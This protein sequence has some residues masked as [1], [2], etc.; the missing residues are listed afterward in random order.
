MVSLKK[1]VWLI[2]TV[3]NAD[4]SLKK[5]L[6]RGYRQ[7]K[8][9]YHPPSP[10]NADIKNIINCMLCP[11]MC[12]FECPAVQASKRE[13][14]APATKSRI[15]YYL[16]M[17][18]LEKTPENIIP[19]FEGCAHCDACKEW[20]PFDFSVGDLLEGVAVD[21]FSADVLPEPLEE[22]TQRLRQNNGLYPVEK[23]KTA[24]KSLQSLDNG[25]IYYF[26]GCTTMAHMADP[27]GL[28]SGIVKISTKANVPLIARPEDRWCCGA[29]SFYAGDIEKVKELALHNQK[30]FDSLKVKSII[31]ECPECT[32]MLRE[33]YPKL[34]IELKIP[35]LHVSEWILSLINEDKISFTK[36]KTETSSINPLSFHDPCVLA[37]KLG[38]IDPPRQI[39][40]KLAP[41][42]LKES[43]Y[44]TNT[45]HC[46]GFGGLVNIA[47]PEIAA[48]MSKQRLNE[49]AQLGVTTIITSCP[50][51]E[52][53]FLKNDSEM[54]FEIKDL[55]EF[56]ASLLE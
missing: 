44:S 39:I 28:I 43:A 47:N 4:W 36:Q 16:E 10:V 55:V 53:S 51:C 37:R 17:E 2:K 38:I 23:Y 5:R 3:L 9:K 33:H 41:A 6:L 34:G 32:Y 11:N 49:F 15:A 45:T 12:R 52:L 54:Q 31:C 35:V 1:N 26:P 7:K 18:R 20:C 56:V 30:H 8:K 27:S 46:C 14:H 48:E 24:I 40:Q 29:P 25:Q 42:A 22:F 21:L 13:T 50:T 19:L